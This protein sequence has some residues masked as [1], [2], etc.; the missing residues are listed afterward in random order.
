MQLMP[1]RDVVPTVQI[2]ASGALGKPITQTKVAVA[3]RHGPCAKSWWRRNRQASE[4][5]RCFNFDLVNPCFTPL[6]LSTAT[7]Q[8]GA[9]TAVESRRAHQLHLA[10]ILIR[11]ERFRLSLWPAGLG[12]AGASYA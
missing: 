11:D 12:L 2:D 7:W 9:S 8:L 4:S 6:P 10:T 5:P 1:L 3:T